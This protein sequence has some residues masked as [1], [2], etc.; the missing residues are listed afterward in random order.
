MKTIIST[1]AAVFGLA[2]LTSLVFANPATLPK[3]PGYPASGFANDTGQ[4]NAGGDAALGESVTASDKHTTQKL[5][6]PN[7]QRVKGSQGAGQLP[8][9]Q[10]PDIKIEPPVSEATRVN[11]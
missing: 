4:T 1:V 3:H 2:L 9:V 5:M 11:R 8:Q 6:D 7:N 10:G